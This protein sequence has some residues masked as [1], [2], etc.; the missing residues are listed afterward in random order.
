MAC[1][2]PNNECN[3][4][5]VE[6]IVYCN[7]VTTIFNIT[8]PEGCEAII[9]PNGNAICRCK[10]TVEPIVEKVKIPV[11]ITDTKYFEDVSWTMA[12]SPIQRSWV[13]FYDFK[14]NYYLSHNDYFQ[15]GINQ[16][17]DETELGL[18]G[19]LLTNRSYQVFYG[20]RYPFT[21]EYQL[22]QSAGNIVLNSL[23]YQAEAIRYSNEYDYSVADS[24]IFNKLWIH[25]MNTNSGE[26]RLVKNTGSLSLI[27]K[28]PKTAVDDSY[29]E[30]LVSKHHNDYTINYFYN[31]IHKNFTHNP[32]WK[33]DFNQIEKTINQEAVKFRGKNILEVLRSKVPTIRLTQ[34]EESRF[35]YIFNVGI[36]KFTADN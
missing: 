19:H 11:S 6:G 16:S 2:C 5:I 33:W 12:Y 30:I 8:C 25:S 20:K 23:M 9:T 13:S 28:Y 35:R 22:K 34:D 27:S 31:R 32:P 18:W 21:V 10:Q 36:S 3:Q 4:Q 14:P 24:T 7:C 17:N 15:T 1:T 29:Q 26:L